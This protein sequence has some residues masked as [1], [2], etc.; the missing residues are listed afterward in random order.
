MQGQPI[1]LAF[2]P[3]IEGHPELIDAP[4]PPPEPKPLAIERAPRWSEKLV[5]RTLGK[6]REHSAR[7]RNQIAYAATARRIEREGA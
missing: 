1:A 5:R 2:V 7:L 6:D 4:P 3:G